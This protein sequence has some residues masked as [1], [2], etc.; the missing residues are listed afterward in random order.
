MWAGYG[1][2]V[3]VISMGDGYVIWACVLV[4]DDEYW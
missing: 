2:W 1:W 3:S 4:M